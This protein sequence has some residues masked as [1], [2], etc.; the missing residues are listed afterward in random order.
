MLPGLIGGHV[1]RLSRSNP[2]DAVVGVCSF[3]GKA[4]GVV[5]GPQSELPDSDT[6]PDLF[7]LG[8]PPPSLSLY[9]SQAQLEH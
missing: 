3:L 9:L 5:C 7:P 4:L 8:L 1:P 2:K 6:A